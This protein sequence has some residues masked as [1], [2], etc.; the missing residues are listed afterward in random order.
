MMTNKEIEEKI[1]SAFEEGD[2]EDRHYWIGY[3]DGKAEREDKAK[4]N[5]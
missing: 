2:E 3:R 5:K 1:E 4:E